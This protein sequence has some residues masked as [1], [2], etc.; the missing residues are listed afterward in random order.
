M[1]ADDG[2]WATA[3]RVGRLRGAASRQS[4]QRDGGFTAFLD[5]AYGISGLSAGLI[6]GQFGYAAVY[7]FSA[8]CAL[9]GAAVVLAAR[10]AR[11]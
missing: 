1:L 9:V 6:A 3:Q 4:R 11:S 8:A 10:R 5:S 7:L 2:L